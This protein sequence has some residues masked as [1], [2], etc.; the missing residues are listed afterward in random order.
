M[1]IANEDFTRL[2]T[3]AQDAYKKIFG[4]ASAIADRPIDASALAPGFDPYQAQAA[5]LLTQGLGS[6][7][8]YLEKA[9]QYAGPQGADAFMNPYTQN[10]VDTTTQQLQKQFGLQQAQADQ[11]AVQ[12]GAFAGSGSRNA[13]FD[14]ALQGEQFDVLGKTVADL[15]SQGYGQAQQAGQNAAGIMGTIGQQMQ[16]QRHA[17]VNALYNLGE[18][19][20]GIGA[21]RA[22]YGY[23]MPMNQA[24]FLQQAYTGMPTW[25]AP[26]MPNPMQMGIASAGAM[27]GWR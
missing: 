21:Q 17:D 5:G 4:Q 10:V 20:R 9:A 25:Q 19:R 1:A 18:Q 24:S 11:R 12:S 27:G 8:P 15:Y 6:Y 23:Q 16:G 22:M 7:V 14:A 26:L 2:P 13:V 3:F